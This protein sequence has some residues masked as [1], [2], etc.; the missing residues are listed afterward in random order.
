MTTMQ[1]IEVAVA[2]ALIVGAVILYRRRGA[3][4]EAKTGS[5]TAVILLVIGLIVGVHGMGLMEYRPSA[6]ELGR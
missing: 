4:G 6:S 3:E 5:Q 1:I 2:A